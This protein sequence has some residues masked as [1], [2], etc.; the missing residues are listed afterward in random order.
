MATAC[1]R[2][3]RATR[4]RLSVAADTLSG[5]LDNGNAVVTSVLAAE[6]ELHHAG[7][8][9]AWQFSSSIGVGGMVRYSRASTTVSATNNTSVDVKVGGLQVGGGIRFR[10]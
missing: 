3:R 8:D 7:A 5:S 9:V 10:F 1:A 4:I 2:S 6:R